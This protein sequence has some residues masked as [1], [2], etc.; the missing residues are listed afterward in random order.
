MAGVIKAIVVGVSNIWRSIARYAVQQKIVSQYK[1]SRLNA[2]LDWLRMIDRRQAF[3]ERLRGVFSEI[4]GVREM[5]SR[6]D[7][8][9]S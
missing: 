5:R 8:E 9:V 7:A 3:Q 1:I 6:P 4:S 2:Y